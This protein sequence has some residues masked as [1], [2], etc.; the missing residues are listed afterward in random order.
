[1]PNK[2]IIPLSILI[3]LFDFFVLSKA[4]HPTANQNYIDY[5]I[6]KNTSVMDY[7]YKE[8]YDYDELRQAH[9]DM[10]TWRFRPICQ[11]RQKEC[12]LPTPSGSSP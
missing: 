11:D 1:M 8:L 6:K 10:E 4:M 9:P 7:Y 2:L 5:F 3:G 12:V